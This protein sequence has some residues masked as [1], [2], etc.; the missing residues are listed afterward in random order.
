M[1][2]NIWHQFSWYRGDAISSNM[3]DD[4]DIFYCNG[5]KHIAFKINRSIIGEKYLDYNEDYSFLKGGYG[6]YFLYGI[7]N[8]SRGKVINVYVG[9]AEARANPHGMDRLVEHVQNDEKARLG[10]H[11]KWNK[12]LYITIKED[13]SKNRPDFTPGVIKALER[14]FIAMFQG[15]AATTNEDKKSEVKII[16]YNSKIG[17]QS[18]EPFDNYKTHIHAIIAL[19]C[20]AMQV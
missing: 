9:K 14:V 17:E 10:Y 19:L 11:N 12:A 15:L 6:I 4:I 20:F 2:S 7:E 8:T 5:T 18:N 16:C 1:T 3:G 13:T